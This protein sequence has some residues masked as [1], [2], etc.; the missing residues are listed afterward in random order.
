M[1]YAKWF[2]FATLSFLLNV[3]LWLTCWLWAIIPAVFKLT[4]LPGP[5]WYFQTHDD[6][7]YGFGAPKPHAPASMWDRWKIATWWIARNPGYGFDS[8]IVG[9][10]ALPTAPKN[11]NDMRDGLTRFMSAD[12]RKLWCYKSPKLWLGWKP[13]Q[14]AGR[15][16]IVV[17]VELKGKR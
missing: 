4:D 9:Y 10:P 8:M 16:M 7:V 6:W 5:L 3:F 13:N 1:R 12:G 14:L 15:H 11:T 17:H 2:I